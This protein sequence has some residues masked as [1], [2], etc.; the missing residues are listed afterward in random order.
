MTDPAADERAA[1]REELL[2]YEAEREAKRRRRDAASRRAV[3][4][5]AAVALA[6]LLYDSGGALAEAARAGRPWGTHAVFTT[7]AALGLLWLLWALVRGIRA[8]H[9]R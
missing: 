5:I 7:A 4:W 2:R 9:R 3:G 1:E 6:F 8:R